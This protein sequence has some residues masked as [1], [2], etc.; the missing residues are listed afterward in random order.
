MRQHVSYTSYQSLAGK[1]VGLFLWAKQMLNETEDEAIQRGERDETI[2]V[3][4]CSFC[5]SVELVI[6][7]DL[8]HTVYCADCG[9]IADNVTVLLSS[10]IN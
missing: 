8:P 7:Y 4:A 2:R 1:L 6:E 3:M 10:E 9:S 5:S